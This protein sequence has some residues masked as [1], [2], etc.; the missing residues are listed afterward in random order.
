MRFPTRPLLMV[1]LAIL[2]VAAS[3]YAAGDAILAPA[4]SAA[5][6]GFLET[7]LAG[8]AVVAAVRVAVIFASAFVVVSVVALISA[9]RWPTRIGPI[10]IADG[11]S[12]LE[13]ENEFLRSAIANYRATIGNVEME[14]VPENRPKTG[15]SSGNDA[16]GR[17]RKA[18]R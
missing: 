13:A 16:A 11:L 10:E 2:L 12:Q 4:P 18:S 14:A 8:R 17:N 9:R 7:I 3:V 15:G 1:P 5:S 6:P